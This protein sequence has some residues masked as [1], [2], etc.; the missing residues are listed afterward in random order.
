ME[1]GA[2]W[3][4]HGYFNRSTR[5]CSL[6]EDKAWIQKSS[7]EGKGHNH[8][9]TSAKGGSPFGRRGLRQVP[10]TIPDVQSKIIHDCYVPIRII[11]NLV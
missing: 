9:K 4:G 8:R 2:P 1:R 7:E 5:S 10:M 3:Q 6:C 11:N